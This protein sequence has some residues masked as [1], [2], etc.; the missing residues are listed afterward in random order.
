[1]TNDD[2]SAVLKAIKALLGWSPPDFFKCSDLN[3][4]KNGLKGFMTGIIVCFFFFIDISDAIV[5]FLL[6]ANSIV[7]GSK[8]KGAL[9][10]WLIVATIVGRLLAAIHANST[11]FKDADRENQTFY[12]IVLEMTVFLVEDGAAIIFLAM[13]PNDGLL[14]TLS[15]WLSLICGCCFIMYVLYYGVKDCIKSEIG[16]NKMIFLLT[17][18][19]PVFMISILLRYVLLKDADFDNAYSG[20]IKYTTFFIY[21]SGSCIAIRYFIREAS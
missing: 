2:S 7:N 17:L 4:C 11:T 18:S 21:V 3:C 8:G 12:Y 13:N 1:M 5:D 20:W 15:S 6:G 14:N 9:G 10:V 16:Q 19:S